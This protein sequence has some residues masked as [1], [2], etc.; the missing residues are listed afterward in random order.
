M[1]PTVSPLQTDREHDEAH[2]VSLTAPA[3]ILHRQRLSGRTV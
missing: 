3:R 1:E 2:L